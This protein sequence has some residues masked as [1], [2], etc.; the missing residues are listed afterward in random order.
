MI[1]LRD[2]NPT[3]R[4]TWMTWS[5]IAVNLAVFGYELYVN[6]AYGSVA[7]ERFVTTW[8]FVPARFLADPTSLLQWATIF[9]AMFMHA[10]FLHVG[11]N[12]LYLW[13]FGNN[14]EDRFGPARF[15]GFYLLCGMAATF[16]QLLAAPHSDIP[17]LGASGAIAGVLAAYLLL[18]PQARVTTAIILIVIIELASLPAWIIIVLWFVLQLA[19]GITGLGRVTAQAGGVAYFAHVGGFVAG[20]LLTL[21]AWASDRYRPKRRSVDWR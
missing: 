17:N 18:Y 5:L 12:M 4:L 3:Q 14:I 6:R 15:L 11:G 8:S 7:F 16:G 10:G 20:L 19:E 1:P 9:T 13:I 21:P 2:E